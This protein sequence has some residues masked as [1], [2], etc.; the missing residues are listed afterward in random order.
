MNSII[1]GTVACLTLAVFA[2]T[3]AG[4]ATQPAAPSGAHRYFD[5]TMKMLDAIENDLPAISTAASQAA[6]LYVEHDLRIGIAGERVFISEL[7]GRCGG[8]MRLEDIRVPKDQEFKGVVLYGL[9]GNPSL[10]EDVFWINYHHKN[11]SRVAV[12]G[13]KEV[14]AR[15]REK[16]NAQFEWGIETH[17]APTGGLIAA[18]NNRYLV[19]TDELGQVIAGWAWTAEFVAACTGLGKMPTMYKG[20]V[21]AGGKERAEKIG[22]AKFHAESPRPVAAEQLAKIYFVE[23]RKSL[24]AIRQNELNDI[25]SLAAAAISARD[26]H[27]G[28]YLFAQNHATMWAFDGPHDANVFTRIGYWKSQRRDVVIEEGDLVFAHGYVGLWSGEDWKHYDDS[29]RAAG[30]KIAWSMGADAAKT[31]TFPPGELFI[32]Q[33][34]ADEDAVVPVEGYDINIIPVSGIG[35]LM[36]YHMTCAEVLTRRPDHSLVKK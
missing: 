18:S 35:E 29:L 12:F 34:F 21:F 36:I 14:L 15:I 11:G 5:Q 13:R 2:A 10:A 6:Q 30:A 25:L 27:K 1:A 20:Y 17:A 19:P 4:Q 9:R 22:D 23:A 24:N 3:L 32:D 33:H 8:M 26:G 7:A 28:V 16:M 31:Y